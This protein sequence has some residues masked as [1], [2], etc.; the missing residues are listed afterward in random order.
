M[1]LSFN[2]ETYQNQYLPAGGTEVHAVVTVTATQTATDAGRAG[3]AV[4]GAAEIV[5]IDVSGS[6]EE[7]RTKLLGAKRA[8]EAALDVLRDGVR[9]G[10]LA[11]SE[12]AQRVYPHTDELAV[13][14]PAT[15]SA[16]TKAIR[17]LRAAGGTALGTWLVEA[18]AWL[19][20]YEDSIRHV[21]L[22]TDGKNENEDV[23]DL[24]AALTRCN[25][26]FQCDCRGVGVDWEVA[27]LRQIATA[28]LGTV[29]IVAE[30]EELAA[31]FTRLMRSAM[32][33]RTAD[34]A[35]RVWVPR[36]TA[37]AVMRQVAPTIEDLM[38]RGV[39]LDDH[40]VEFT[41]GAWS[42]E[43]RDYHVAVSVVPRAIDDTILAGRINL[44]VDGQVVSQ[45]LI[46]A[47]WTD[48]TSLST[49]I[50]PHVAHYTGQAE[51][52]AAIASGLEARRAD[53]PS[54]ATFMLGRAARLAAAS[55]NDESLRLLAKIVD[56]D[57]AS[58]GTVRLR[59]DISAA[60]EMALDTR[61]TKTV[62]VRPTA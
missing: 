22:L 25:G 44:V 28:L 7:P 50:N 32:A 51:L 26:A 40:T 57:D 3:M 48:D 49:V 62:R 61:S 19:E 15:R 2:A 39:R 56:I 33:R 42:A 21:I 43:A 6:M 5:I 24:R 53:D 59:S 52:A 41:T 11:G 27:E 36:G 31:D 4:S 16:A 17:R 20:P 18:A 23:E 38:A 45:S 47:T 12:G 35:L 34:V 55:G 46:K 14:S 37:I 29:D 13:A 8:A 10:I 1:T 58:S 9:F 60:D 54:T 30:P